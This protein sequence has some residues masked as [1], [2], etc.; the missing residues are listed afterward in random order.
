MICCSNS[1]PKSDECKLHINNYKEKGFIQVCDYSTWGAGTAKNKEI[2][3][4]YYCG[5]NGNYNMFKE[6]DRTNN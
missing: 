4:E 5:P 3:I 2:H 1:C 6:M